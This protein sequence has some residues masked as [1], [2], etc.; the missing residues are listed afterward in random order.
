MG[1]QLRE[2]QIS[3]GRGS[4][5]VDIYHNQTRW[6]ETLNIHVSKKRPSDEDKEKRRLANEIRSKRENELI[7][8]DNDLV[9]RTKNKAN[10]V[11]WFENYMKERKLDYS[12]NKSTLLH[13]KNY[14]DGKP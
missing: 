4:F 6:Y 7:V 14:M 13:L 11:V 10:F 9:D 8:Q 2:K 5:Y 3:G 12:H 1:V